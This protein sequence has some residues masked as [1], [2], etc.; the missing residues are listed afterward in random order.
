M[1]YEQ[2]VMQL[3]ASSG[4]ARSLSLKLY[5]QHVVTMYRVQKRY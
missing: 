5:E 2:A 3:I 4:E 1:D